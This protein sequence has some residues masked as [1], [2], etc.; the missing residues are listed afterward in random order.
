MAAVIP[1]VIMAACAAVE[2]RRPAPSLEGRIQ[3]QLV[4][5]D[6][7]VRLGGVEIRA[8][9]KSTV[10]DEQGRFAFD[11]LPQGKIS[12]VA[13]KGTGKGDAGRMMGVAVL[14]VGENPA[15]FKIPFRNAAFVDRFCEE[16]HPYR[17][18]QPIRQGQII[19]DVHVSGIVPKKAAKWPESVDSQGRIT[20]ESC[21]TTHENTKYGKFL[22][23]LK[24]GPLC[25]KCH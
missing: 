6:N 10:T 19:R 16:C 9:G 21:H 20:C 2:P 23:D 7:S 1:I 13:E 22:V 15:Q 5:Q 18:K 8:A 4:P 11:T 3:G 24:S 17:P 25:K 14:Y 12:I